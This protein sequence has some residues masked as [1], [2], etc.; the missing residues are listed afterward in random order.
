MTIPPSFAEQSFLVKPVGYIRSSLMHREEA[1]LQGDEG[2][3]AA[4]VEIQPAFVAALEG[5]EKD[6]E[7]LLLTW[8]HEAER[9]ILQV[10]PRGRKENPV[11]GVFATRS[12]SRPN[13]V[14]IHRVSVL[15]VEG[16]RIQVGPL[17]AIDGTPVIDIKPVLDEIGER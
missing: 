16:T 9:D 10:H 1:P 17:E 12:P 7:L 14:G 3:P 5:I 13:P 2:A 8:L 4:W 15:K 6:D 11:T